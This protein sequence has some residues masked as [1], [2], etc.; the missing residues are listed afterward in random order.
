[1][2]R[3]HGHTIPEFIPARRR[4]ALP[5]GIMTLG[6]WLRRHRTRLQ[7]RALDAH[8]LQ[9]IGLSESQRDRECARWFWQGSDREAC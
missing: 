6:I 5:I 4:A 3:S 9:D 2:D 1:M 8:D 7:L